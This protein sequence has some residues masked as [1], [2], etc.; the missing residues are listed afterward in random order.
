MTSGQLSHAGC[1][2]TQADS[3]SGWGRRWLCLMNEELSEWQRLCDGSVG[4][5]RWNQ[6]ESG[7]AD[8]GPT[9]AANTEEMCLYL[10]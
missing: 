6:E 5:N 2:I 10:T 8:S 3:H 1:Y 4:G 9:S 7:E